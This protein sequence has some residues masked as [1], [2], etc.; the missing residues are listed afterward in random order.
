MHVESCPY[1]KRKRQCTPTNPG[2]NVPCPERQTRGSCRVPETEQTT[3]SSLAALSLHLAE[4]A[5]EIELFLV[6]LLVPQVS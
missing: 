3:T 4:E 1:C 5:V 2:N 6:L